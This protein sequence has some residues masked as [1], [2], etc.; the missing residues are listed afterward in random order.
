MCGRFA[1]YSPAEATAALFGVSDAP[2]VAPRY[3]IAPTQPVVVVRNG[4]RGRELVPMRWG[5]VPHWQKDPKATAPLILARA[6]RVAAG[7][8]G[9]PMVS[10]ADLQL[11][12][13]PGKRVAVQN[14]GG[15]ANLTVLPADGAL[16]A[17]PGA[18]PHLG[19][20]LCDAPV[21]GNAPGCRWPH[22]EARRLPSAGG[23]FRERSPASLAGR[24]S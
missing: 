6:D 12:A 8:Q 21:G 24:R 2:P 22:S 10:F 4:H 3:N 20:A 16:H 18:C 5:L 7:G 23:G 15:I 19:A 9:A 1:F 17:G 13:R 14:I 11:L